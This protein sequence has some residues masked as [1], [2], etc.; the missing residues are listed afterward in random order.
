MTRNQRVT[1]TSFLAIFGVY[2]IFRG[3]ENHKLLFFSDLAVFFVR[4]YCGCALGLTPGKIWPSE[5]PSTA[6]RV[7]QNH[8]RRTLERRSVTSGPARCHRLSRQQRAI[9]RRSSMEPVSDA[10]IMFLFSWYTRLPNR[11]LE[12]TH[13]HRAHRAAVAISSAFLAKYL[14]SRSESVAIR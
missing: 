5:K 8:T 1:Q 10:V 7:H 4:S 13:A 11:R 12:R 3:S 6:H 2:N 14:T 9:T